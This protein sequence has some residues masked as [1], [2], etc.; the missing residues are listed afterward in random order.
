M[1]ASIWIDL[2]HHVW[3]NESRKGPAW[4]KV[5]KAQDLGETKIDHPSAACLGSPDA[6]F[7]GRLQAR[8]SSAHRPAS[9]GL[10]GEDVPAP[11]RDAC[12]TISHSRWYLGATWEATVREDGALSQWIRAGSGK[13]LVDAGGARLAA[14]TAL[15]AP[16]N[17]CDMAYLSGLRGLIGDGFAQQSRGWTGG[18]R[19][20]R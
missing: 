14:P 15:S 1:D 6:P 7:R 5:P 19:R 12:R 9:T 2:A 20:I 16:D 11:M 4:N 17:H 10:K 8:R 18:T 3:Y 13:D